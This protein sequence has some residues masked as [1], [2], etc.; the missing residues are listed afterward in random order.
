MYGEVV[1]A[2]TEMCMLAGQA[3]SPFWVTFL[4]CVVSWTQALKQAITRGFQL[5]SSSLHWLE[6]SGVKAYAHRSH[7]LVEEAREQDEL[8]SAVELRREES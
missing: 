2:S 5:W 1:Y 6:K 7:Q 4:C 3:D 8:A